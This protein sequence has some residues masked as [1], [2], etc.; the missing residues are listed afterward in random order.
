MSNP[1]ATDRNPSREKTMP[2]TISPPEVVLN[3]W[4]YASE[5]GSIVRLAARCYVMR[6]TDDEKLA[7]L[8]QLARTV[9]LSAE[10]TPVPKNFM[11]VGAGGNQRGVAHASMLDDARTTGLLFG[12]LMDRLGS[13]SPSQVHSVAGEYVEFALELGE[14]PLTCTTVVFE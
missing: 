10:W 11:S 5:Q 8:R 1:E 4:A 6:G 2:N 14:D 3:L 9:F 13:R 7:L 12:P